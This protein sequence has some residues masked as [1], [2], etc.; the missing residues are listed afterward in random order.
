MT[1]TKL[2]TLTVAAILALGTT[3][4]VAESEVNANDNTNVDL[5][6]DSEVKRFCSW[7]FY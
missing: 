5:I 2:T 1:K 7:N 6:L 4:L 3:S